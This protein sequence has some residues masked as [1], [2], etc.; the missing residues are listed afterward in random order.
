MKNLITHLRPWLCATLAAALYITSVYAAEIGPT[1]DLEAAVAGL[2]PGE[3]LVLRGGLYSFNGN[4]TI[5]A[6]GTAAQPITIR[7]KSGEQPIFEQAT[8]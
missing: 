5:T 3:E 7:A 1:D 2:S 6:N 8:R 4:V